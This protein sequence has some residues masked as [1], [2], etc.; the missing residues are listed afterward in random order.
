MST[1]RKLTIDDLDVKGKRV[2]V[3]VDFNVPLKE[4]EQGNLVV[5]DDTRIREALPTIRALMQAGAKVIL[6]SHLGRPK[7]QPDPKYSL[8]PVARRLEELLGVRVR[9]VSN[10][11]GEAVRQAI[12]SMPEGGVI[13][14]ENTR[15]HP[16]ETKNDP[17]LARQLA[18]LADVYVNDAF[19][20]AHRAHASTE[21]VAH[22]VKQAAMGYLMKREVEYLGRLL[23][24]PEHPFVA[25]LGGA[26][27]SDKIGVIKN[28][29]PR[30]D[31]LL[32]GGAMSYTFLKA[33]GHNVGASRV[34]EDRLEEARQL[35]E[36]AQGKILLPVDHVVAPEFSNEAPAQ[37]VE[38]DI[39]DG[40]MGLDIG[41]KTIER[42]REEI[43]QARTV[44][45]N[46][47]MGVFEMPNFAK[48]TFAIAEAL[49]EA[50]DRGALT[51]VGGGDSVAAITQ[52]GYADRVS[53]VSTGGGAMLEFLEGKEL[54]GL[55]ALT[56]KK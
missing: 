42:Y 30:V 39:P 51:V 44:V 21:G 33:L 1:L 54:P 35:Y 15:F 7:G 25:I 22:Y 18:E 17:E 49:A 27:V 23:E 26:K 5:A 37:V 24:N 41:P 50:T 48:G 40:L 20:S 11:V 47:P 46:G 38:G 3:R 32:I 14:L 36:E 56:D 19:G 55:I 31:R 13:L 2:L 16:G 28:L 9:F 52:A 12:N 34:E 43:L 53:H 45:W 8:A 10:I 29:L 4:D 6:M